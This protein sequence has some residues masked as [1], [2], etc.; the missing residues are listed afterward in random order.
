MGVTGRRCGGCCPGCR[1]WCLIADSKCRGGCPPI[2]CRLC[3]M[4][5]SAPMLAMRGQKLCRRGLL[6]R[7]GHS[8]YQPFIHF[9]CFDP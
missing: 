8:R 1:W 4:K 7:Q 3:S 9:M 2:E 5:L 6:V